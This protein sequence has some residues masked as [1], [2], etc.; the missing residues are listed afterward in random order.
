MEF[1]STRQMGGLNQCAACAVNHPI[2]P[3]KLLSSLLQDFLYL[4]NA[5]TV[6]TSGSVEPA[7]IMGGTIKQSLASVHA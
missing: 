5:F 1:L 7:H 2:Y 6:K 3:P 4:R